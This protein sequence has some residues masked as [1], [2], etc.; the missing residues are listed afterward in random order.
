MKVLYAYRDALQKGGLP[1]YARTLAAGVAQAGHDVSLIAVDR[2]DHRQIVDAPA[3]VTAYEVREGLNGQRQFE[4]LLRT[5]QP[6][7]VHFPG[8]PRNWLHTPWSLHLRRAGIP[9]VLSAAG[10]LSDL[11]YRYRWG[12][13]RNSRL[14]F[15]AKRAYFRFVDRA[16]IKGAEA[17]HATSRNE[18]EIAL[19]AGAQSVFTLP[20]GM[21]SEKL[22]NP[23]WHRTR[24]RRPVTFTYLGRLSTIHKGLDLI[25]EAFG[26]V[27]AAGYRDAFRLVLAG[28][29]EGD[30]LDQL[31]SRAQELGITN[32]QFPGATY[33]EEKRLLWAESDVFL[34]MCRFTGFALAMREALCAGLPVIASRESDYGDWVDEYNL[35]RVSALDPD[36]LT[37]AILGMLRIDDTDYASI[38]RNVVSYV[39]ETRWPRIGE[40]FA[41][42]Y[43]RLLGS[44][45]APRD[46]KA[47]VIREPLLSNPV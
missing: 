6:D 3:G 16:M 44:A 45:G 28:P 32:I 9:Y 18:A 47:P 13:K 4:Y 33:G 37:A 46:S 30:S 1:E 15:V 27:V 40:R 23:N 10:T 8:G 12:G 36:A 21:M 19:R 31:R 20:F 2:P 35:G 39:H 14:H 25:V 5:I 26:K 43:D 38:S 7:I 34:H 41:S 17:V 24:L 42:E 29:T 22:P 11:T